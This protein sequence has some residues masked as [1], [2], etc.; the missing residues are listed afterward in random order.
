MPKHRKLI[1]VTDACCR[2]PALPNGLM[3]G[4]GKAASAFV[5][6]DL[7][8]QVIYKQ[9]LFLGQMTPPQ[10]EYN[11]LINALDAAAE[12]CRYSLDIWLD[13]ELV[14]KQLIGEYGLRSEPLKILYDQVKGLEKRFLGAINY[15]HHSRGSYWARYV[16]KLAN[17]EYAKVQSG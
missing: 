14:V 12:Y 8:R 4:S 13:S 6:L 11:G 7:N 10:A 9:A 17:E 16:D 15:F 1:I 2:I 5:F 3:A